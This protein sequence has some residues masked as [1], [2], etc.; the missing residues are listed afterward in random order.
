MC[1]FRATPSV[2][3][4]LGACTGA[5]EVRYCERLDECNALYG[6]SV[7]ECETDVSDFLADLSNDEQRDCE[8]EIDACLDE[9]SCA[10]FLACDTSQCGFVLTSPTY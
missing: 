4:L 2:V 8:D 1:L 7:E 5:P 10:D 6:A 3:F 9:Q